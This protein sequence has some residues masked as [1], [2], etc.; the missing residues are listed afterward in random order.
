MIIIYWYSLVDKE[1]RI[2]EKK[3]NVISHALINGLFTVLSESREIVHEKMT[4][5]FFQLHN[6]LFYL[7]YYN[8]ISSCT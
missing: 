2:I 6:I 3:D 7:L 1:H 5:F 4:L 8:Q